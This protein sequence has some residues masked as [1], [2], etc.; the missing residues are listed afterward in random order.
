MRVSNM[1]A[2]A[3]L[4]RYTLRKLSFLTLAFFIAVATTATADEN[5]GEISKAIQM[6]IPRAASIS[7]ADWNKLAKSETAPSASNA[8]SQTLGVLF[9]VLPLPKERTAEHDAEFRFLAKMP[10]P[11]DLAKAYQPSRLT[12]LVTPLQASYIKHV[13]AAVDRNRATGTIAYEAPG[14][15]A[16][17]VEYTARHA[18]EKWEIVEFR[19]PA[20]GMKTSLGD[21]GK[22]K[23]STVPRR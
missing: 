21:D 6:A 9:L 14:T 11:S 1:L 10:K 19:L 7:R 17:K 2:D 18:K 13:T 22:W 23:I 15:Y 5:E 4:V 20:W 3:S 12:L 16:G 8:E